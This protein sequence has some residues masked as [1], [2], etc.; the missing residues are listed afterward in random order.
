M[1][2][3]FD[4]MPELELVPGKTIQIKFRMPISGDSKLRVFALEEKVEIMFDYIEA[5]H[6]A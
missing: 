5:M 3:R 4:S 1:R 6:Q 2:K